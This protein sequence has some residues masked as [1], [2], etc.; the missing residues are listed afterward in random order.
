MNYTVDRN[1][2][3]RHFVR[4]ATRFAG[5]NATVEH[6]APHAKCQDQMT[7]GLSNLGMGKVVVSR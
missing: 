5:A 2:R 1:S 6:L 4:S 7:N 3:V